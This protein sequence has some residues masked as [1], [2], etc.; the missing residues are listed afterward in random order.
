MVE[1]QLYCSTWITH[2]QSITATWFQQFKNQQYHDQ[3]WQNIIGDLNMFPLLNIS[4]SSLR[5]G[6]KLVEQYVRFLSGN[7]SWLWNESNFIIVV[8]IPLTSVSAF[9][10]RCVVSTGHRSIVIADSV[11]IIHCTARCC[12]TSITEKSY[13]KPHYDD[14]I[15]TVTT[16]II[17]LSVLYNLTYCYYYCYL[18]HNLL[19]AIFFYIF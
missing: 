15:I 17:T 12:W 2:R 18:A 6:W 11:E 13:S 16:I 10:C 3:L 5:Q 14:R 1:P 7:S 8:E 4:Q 9:C 19:V